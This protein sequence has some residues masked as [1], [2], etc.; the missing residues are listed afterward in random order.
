M[1]DKQGYLVNED[2][3]KVFLII[4]RH[5]DCCSPLAQT[6]VSEEPVKEDFSALRD[7][8]GGHGPGLEADRQAAINDHCIRLPKE[9]LEQLPLHLHKSF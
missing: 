8:H 5:E 7:L 3:N 2:W 4:K 1:Q 9:T 6:W